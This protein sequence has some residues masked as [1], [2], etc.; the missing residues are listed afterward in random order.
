MYLWIKLCKFYKTYKSETQFSSSHLHETVFM[1][2]GALIYSAASF[3]LIEYIVLMFTFMIKI[4]S[5]VVVI[6]L[7]NIFV[8]VILC[9]LV[10]V[11]VDVDR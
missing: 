2:L 3:P 9:V 8:V 10:C 1:R 5:P 4:K 11:G 7:E 6:R